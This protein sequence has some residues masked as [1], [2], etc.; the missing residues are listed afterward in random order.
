MY[1]DCDIAL[2]VIHSISKIFLLNNNTL[3]NALFY[4]DRLIFLFSVYTIQISH[5]HVYKNIYD[6]T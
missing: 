6:V 3:N 5:V 1:A 4:Q 2:K